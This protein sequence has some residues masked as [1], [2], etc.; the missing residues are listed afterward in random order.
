M[1][2][3]FHIYADDVQIYLKFNRANHFSDWSLESGSLERTIENRL[4]LILLGGNISYCHNV[5]SLGRMIPLPFYD[6]RISRSWRGH[7]L[8]II[9]ICAF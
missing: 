3:C 1:C 5:D 2:R 6:G 9:I 8:L 7:T 4:A